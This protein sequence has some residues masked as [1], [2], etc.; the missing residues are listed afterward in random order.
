MLKFLAPRAGRLEREY[1]TLVRKRGLMEGHAQFRAALTKALCAIT[2]VAA[3]RTTGLP[4]FIEQVQYFGR[5]LAKLNVS[6]DQVNEALDLAAGI[7][8]RE[9]SGA[10]GPAREQLRLVTM[11]ALNNAYCVVRESET[12]TLFALY[13]AEL[14]SAGIEET[15]GRIARE[16]VRAFGARMGRI[17]MDENSRA[18]R[19]SKPLYIEP[20]ERDEKLIPGDLRGCGSWWRYPAG[21][22]VIELGFGGPYPWLPRELALLEAAARRCEQAL[23]RAELERQV[24]RL[25]AESHL[26]EQEERR[27]IGRELHDETGQNLI[28]LR[29]Q[30]EMMER[31]SPAPLRPRLAESRRLVERA[32]TE[33]RRI[34]AALSP[35]V[36]E[37]LGLLAALRQ[38]A[39]RFHNMRSTT[40]RLRLPARLPELS[41]QAEEV[42]YRVAQECLNNAARHSGAANVNLSLRLADRT[43]RLSIS[44]DGVGFARAAGDKS[45]SF[46]MAGM[47]DRA[48]LVRGKLSIR[49]APGK[50]TAVVLEVPLVKGSGN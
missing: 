20:G 36:L 14:E 37:R 12:E 26:A 48:A 3:A 7:L 39:A 46:G 27:R 44:D 50:G 41:K 25:R 6:T 9:L 8:E 42:I 43:V 30:L 34:M 35:T 5:R 10:C 16:L 45:Q 33:L 38:L 2:P 4:A 1:R 24:S 49:S 13:L 15:F 31:S 22:A 40:V 32:V 17:S 21:P 29:L 23:R 28:L 19:R 18:A 47:R 11:L